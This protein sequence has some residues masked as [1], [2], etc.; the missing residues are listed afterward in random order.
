MKEFD[1]LIEVADTLMGPGGCPWDHKQTFA[2]LKPYVLEEAHE[3]LEAVDRQEDKEMIE[4]LGDLLYTVIFY[5]KIAQKEKRFSIREILTA[6]KEKLIRRHPHVFG[7]ASNEMDEVVKNW[8]KI[9]KEEKKERKSPFDGI[10]KTLP[11]LHRA[12]MMC[13]RGGLFIEKPK[14]EQEEYAAKILEMV[15]EANEKKIDLEGALREILN[16]TQA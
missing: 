11:S 8:E 2:S 6:I 7:D 9:K 14:T 16:R 1:E 10:P 4:E 13:K 3:V 5:A 12:Q 15:L